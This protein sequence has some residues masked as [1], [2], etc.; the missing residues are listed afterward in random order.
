H[1]DVPPLIRPPHAALVFDGRSDY[2]PLGTSRS[3]G[4][5]GASFTVECWLKADDGTLVGDRP[6]LGM[7]AENAGKDG[8][9]HLVLR[10]GVPYMGFWGDDLQGP[11]PL[12]A[13]AWYHVAWRFN[14]GTKEQTI[15]VDGVRVASRAAEGPMAGDGP[16]YLARYNDAAFFSGMLSDLRIWNVARSDA[17]I[18]DNRRSYRASYAIRGPVDG[19]GPVEHLFEIPS[20]GGLALVSRLSAEHEQRLLAYRARE[21]AQ[22]KAAT[23]VDAAHAS[24]TA[25]VDAKG[26]ELDKTH[27]EQAAAIDAKK[28][29]HED[30]R[31][32]NRTRYAQGQQDAARRIDGANQAASQKRAD[33][34]GQAAQTVQNANVSADQMK[35]QARQNVD[36][37]Q[38]ARNKYN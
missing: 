23:D 37:A 19:A 17:Q 18:S 5:L 2:I 35:N 28:A 21:E 29:E 24:Y 20:S 30:D 14:A 26:Q 36:A 27:Q 7:G 12:V 38:Q 33:A 9:L 25:Q 8:V 10:N 11:A 4:L 32:A 1:D 13:G 22:K 3:L 6:V 16:V 15:F 31:T 34:Q